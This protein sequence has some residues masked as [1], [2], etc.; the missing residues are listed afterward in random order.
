MNPFSGSVY[1]S[2][3]THNTNVL[4]QVYQHL[5]FEVFDRA[6]FSHVRLTGQHCFDCGIFN[7]NAWCSHGMDS[8]IQDPTSTT[9]SRPGNR[10]NRGIRWL[11]DELSEYD[12]P[13]DVSPF[14]TADNEQESNMEGK[15]FSVP[16]EPE[17]IPSSIV[18]ATDNEQEGLMEQVIPSS[19]VAA[20]RDSQLQ[21][22]TTPEQPARS[23]FVGEPPT[24]S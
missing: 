11:F 21:V 3:L 9:T 13:D 17:V 14:S 15:S 1:S 5:P 6:A 24:V 8:I 22:V 16:I 19:I 12:T 20:E 7:Y 18:S 23:N 2:V 4:N 10:T